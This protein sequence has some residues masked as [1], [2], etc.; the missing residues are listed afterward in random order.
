M[1]RTEGRDHQIRVRKARKSFSKVVPVVNT[2]V[3][4]Q[5]KIVFL[6]L[7]LAFVRA[8]QEVEEEECGDEK[9]GEC[10]ANLLL[11]VLSDES[12]EVICRALKETS[13]CLD[14][15]AD[16]CFGDNKDPEL[17]DGLQELRQIVAT[18]CPRGDGEIPDDIE[19][20]VTGLEDELMECV[21]DSIAQT[22][23]N[24]IQLPGDE[25]PDENEIKCSMYETVSRCVV[26][27]VE[28][29]CGK[30]AA[31][32]ALAEMVDAPEDIKENCQLPNARDALK[33]LMYDIAKRRRK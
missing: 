32:I 15:T 4:M 5:L 9:A 24:I 12:E 33:G 25:E 3:A 19:Q 18:N 10:I 22:L 31:Q 21:S 11:A 1:I 29:S 30:E 2:T 16:E 14:E 8:E 17:E 23:D 28:D 20:C 7:V 13:Q 6:F 27:K 26:K